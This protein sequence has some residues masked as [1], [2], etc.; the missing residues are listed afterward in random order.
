MHDK[1]TNAVSDIA[2]RG[3]E[4]CSILLHV[5]ESL[6]WYYEG[7][8]SPQSVFSW[9][10]GMISRPGYFLF[11]SPKEKDGL[12]LRCSMIDKQ[13]N[14]PPCSGSAKAP[15]REFCNSLP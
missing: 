12:D 14:T 15:V 9:L 7:G 3:N 4:V 6:I 1:Q 8:V 5:E 10:A 13:P 2:I 11:A